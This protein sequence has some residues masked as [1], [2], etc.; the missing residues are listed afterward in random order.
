MSG[1]WTPFVENAFLR[2]ALLA[3]VLVSVLCAFIGTFVVLRGM[4]FVGDALAHGVLPGIAVASLMGMSTVGGAAVGA[5]VMMGGIRVVQKRTR[6]SAD[7]AIG[8]LF[9]GMLSLGVIIT[10]RSDTFTGDL[11][12]VLFGEVLG[13][14]RARIAWLGVATAVVALTVTLLRR[15]F[16]LLCVDDDIA[17][18]SGFSSSRYNSAML[19]LVGLAVVASF[20]TVGT[21]LVFGMLLAPAATAALVTRRI[22]TMILVAAAAGSFSAWLGLLLSYHHDLAAGATVVV[23]AVVLFVVTL[24]LRGGSSG[25]VSAHPSHGAHPHPGHGQSGHGH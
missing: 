18:T 23:T 11:A 9:V 14:T 25:F 1:L 7:T 21:L 17:D 15:P 4:A 3:G 20:Q 19:G 6:L 22:G 2:D 24:L 16:M 5:V 13:V 8:L 10:S 12:S